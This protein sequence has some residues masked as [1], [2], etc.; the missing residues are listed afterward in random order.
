MGRPRS[1]GELSILKNQT[2]KFI[3]AAV[4]LGSASDR[5][6]FFWFSLRQQGVKK[7][8]QPQGSLVEC[9]FNLDST[10]MGVNSILSLL[11]GGLHLGSSEGKKLT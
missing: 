10:P 7:N 6:G 3:G 1:G 2:S 4:S 9:F 8:K 11:L 5:V